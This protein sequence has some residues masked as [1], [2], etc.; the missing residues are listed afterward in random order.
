MLFVLIVLAL[1]SGCHGTVYKVEQTRSMMETT[2]TITV[3]HKDEIVAREAI[4]KAFEAMKRVDEVMSPYGSTSQV[5]ILNRNRAIK[6][7]PEL[8]FVIEKSLFYSNLSSGAFDIT[9]QP[10][11]DLYTKAF[12]VQNMTP[13]DEEIG[14]ALAFVGYKKITVKGDNI[15]LA[16]NMSIT[17]GGIAKGYAIDKAIEVLQQ[18]GISR[19]L[20]NAGGQVRAIG[21]KVGEPWEVA[22]QNPRNETQYVTIIAVQNQSVSTSGDYVRYFDTEKKFHHI[23]NPRTGYSATELISVTIIA[24]KGIDADALSTTVFVLGKEKGIQLVEKL[25]NV[26]ALIITRDREIIRSSGFKY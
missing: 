6:A 9:V 20:V 19:A 16:P 7:D 5:R 10:I 12:S 24:P 22:L 23:I 18:N 17:L 15:S 26:E 11:L 25:P 2:V 4:R 21:A 3:I 1:V 8:I 14:S 13:T